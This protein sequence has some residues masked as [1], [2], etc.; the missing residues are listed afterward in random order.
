MGLNLA[1][2]MQLICS[3]NQLTHLVR[4]QAM[5]VTEHRLGY[6]QPSAP[7]QLFPGAHYPFNYE[8]LGSCFADQQHLGDAG[9]LGSFPAR[10]QSHL[11][12]TRQPSR[13]QLS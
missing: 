6:R 4:T 1:Q 3:F 7:T 12:L 8:L 5:L 13:E 11:M 10:W 2:H 9:G